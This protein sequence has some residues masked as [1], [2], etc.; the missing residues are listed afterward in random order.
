MNEALTKPSMYEEL[1][2]K[3]ESFNFETIRT[4][5]LAGYKASD[6]G[7]CV[8]T[9]NRIIDGDLI[10]WKNEWEKTADCVFAKAEQ[11]AKD[12]HNVSAEHAFYRASN[13]YNKA[14]FYLVSPNE[15]SE[16]I[17]LRQ[18]AV[19]AFK[20][21]IAYKSNISSVNIPYENTT[22]PA[23]FV[24]SNSLNN[25][26]APL[27]I[28]HTGFDGTKEEM[29]FMFG[30][31][32]IERGYHLLLLDGPGQGES[33]L[34][35]LYY[36]FDW[37][38]VITPVVDFALTLACVDKD[39]IALYGASMGGYLAPRAVAFEPRINAC[40]ANGGVSNFFAAMIKVLPPELI[41]LAEQHPELFNQKI[42]EISSKNVNLAW[43]FGNG[44]WTMGVKTNAE[45]F[46][47]IKLFNS[48]AVSGQIKCNMLII[49]SRKDMFF[50]DQPRELY[51][52][53]NCP[54]EYIVFDENSPGQYHCQ[55]GATK[56]SN[57]IIYAW[58]DKVLE[59]RV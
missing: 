49:D 5:G 34:N 21:G 17:A 51:N 10:S 52:L 23:Y 6:F 30:L 14:M 9:A 57:E 33:L 40:I 36:R 38:K 16:A 45:F 35:N 4:I 1:F 55:M 48:S 41:L 32:A 12:G 26:V 54:K 15:R 11:F 29:Y 46:Q 39:K 3:D 22:L 7:E 53:L 50:D 44:K 47:K 56:F 59:H 42:D 8:I 20:N 37:E 2:F 13:Y 58:L 18:K 19:L 27:M 43:A 31:A 25:G 24:E 28:L